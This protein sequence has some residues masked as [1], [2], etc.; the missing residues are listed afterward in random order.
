VEARRELY[1]RLQRKYR[2]ATRELIAW[3]AELKLELA[4][5]EDAEGS[6]RA[7]GGEARCVRARRAHRGHGALEAA[8]QGRGR[9]EHPAL[10]RARAARLPSRPHRVRGE[11]CCGV[12]PER[13]RARR[14]ESEL[15][16]S[17]SASRRDRW[18]RSCRAGAVAGHVELEDG[19]GTH[20]FR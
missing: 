10:A 6:L 2:R 15:L 4:Q 14:G 17:T 8:A 7:G 19:A 5:G 3:R 18:P 11:A 9:V 1:A 20:G 12:R 13:H 16:R